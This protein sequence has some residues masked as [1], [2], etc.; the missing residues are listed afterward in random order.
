MNFHHSQFNEHLEQRTSQNM[1]KRQRTARVVLRPDVEAAQPYMLEL[2]RHFHRHP[3]LSFEESAT[4]ARVA[5]ELVALGLTPTTG[6]APGHGITATIEGGVPGGPCVALRSDM[7]ALPIQE[8]GSLP[9]KSENAGV[10]HACGHDAHMAILLGAA[11]CLVALRERMCGSVK[12]IFQ[13]AEENATPE[14]PY[15]GAYEMVHK[16]SPPVLEGVSSIYGLHVWSYNH[17]GTIGVKAGGVMASCDTFEINVVGKGGHGAEPRGTVDAVVVAAHLVG[18]IQ[19][20]VARSH[21]PKT[22]AVITV[23]QV[24]DKENTLVVV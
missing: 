9:C 12:L 11:K 10:M 2:R 19:T 16:S 6:I 21:D 24:R 4:A 20:I 15:G 17:V 18:A 22:N 14:C 7:D 13:P 3:E 8:E 23:G 1:S 5:A